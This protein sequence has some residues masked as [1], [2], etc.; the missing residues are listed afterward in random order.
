M[1]IQHPKRWYDKN[2][3]VKDAMHAW[4]HFPLKLQTVLADHIQTLIQK[5]RFTMR[6]RGIYKLLPNHLKVVYKAR[7]KKRWYDH[8]SSTY[9]TI[10]ALALVEHADLMEIARKIIQ[11]RSYLND[12]ALQVEKLANKDLKVLIHQIFEDRRNPRF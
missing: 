10:N 2:P 9:K 12:H 8:Y 5:E 6:Y 7:Q 1:S 11:L 4:E 3:V